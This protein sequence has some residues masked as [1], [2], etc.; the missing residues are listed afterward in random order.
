MTESKS[1]RLQQALKKITAVSGVVGAAIVARNGL[2][3][4][5]DLPREVD[6]RRLGAM[7]ATMMGAVET[8]S[9]TL[10]KGSVRR[11]IAE[12]E[13]A[14]IAAM[15]AGPKAILVC[16]AQNGVSLGMLLLEMEEQAMNVK[17]ILGG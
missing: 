10:N 8:A 14:T 7:T 2:L 1:E 3:M 17:G 16:T 5:S 4:A 13:H 6:E 12:V 9:I 15:G 11:V